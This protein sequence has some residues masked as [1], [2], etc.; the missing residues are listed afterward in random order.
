MPRF[1]V[2]PGQQFTTPEANAL[3]RMQ[4][5]WQSSKRRGV[6][7]KILHQEDSQ[8][9][10]WCYNATGSNLLHGQIV[11]IDFDTNPI[12]PAYDGWHEV[13]L[14]RG[15]TPTTATHSGSFGVCLEP[16]PSG[17]YGPVVIG[18][19]CRCRLSVTSASDTYAE[20][21]NNS[22][23]YLTTSTTGT[24]KILYKQTGTGE[25]W[26]IVRLGHSAASARTVTM[27]D[28]PGTKETSVDG[29]VVSTDSG[30]LYFSQ[31]TGPADIGVTHDPSEATPS[32]NGN[33]EVTSSGLYEISL[34]WRV[35]PDAAGTAGTTTSHYVIPTVRMFRKP[36][37]GAFGLIENGEMY[38]FMS[39]PGAI[40]NGGTNT[41]NSVTLLANLT[42][43]DVLR[44]QVGVASAPSTW[45]CYITQALISFE[46][47]GDQIA[48]VA[49]P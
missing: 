14:V 27:W 30:Y 11:G 28:I 18:G 38:N 10:A 1:S 21:T 25:K 36:L 48:A 42:D 37:A 23:S 9:I 12:D 43:G 45:E 41:T 3:L 7:D 46:R 8:T 34:Y 31:R 13:M 24:A 29:T 35:E 5:E 49:I 33:F 20:V 2:S 19:A 15:E 4:R 17:E 44:I 39:Y 47:L 6:G 40:D 32:T 16:I 26:G 22:V